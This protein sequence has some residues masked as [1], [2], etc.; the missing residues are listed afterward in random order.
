M[1]HAAI[2]AGAVAAL[3]L[4]GTRTCRGRALVA[5]MRGAAPVDCGCGCTDHTVPA[6]VAVGELHPEP[7]ELGKVYRAF[8]DVSAL[9]P[10]LSRID[11]TGLDLTP[12]GCGS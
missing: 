10:T 9:Q 3:Y 6:S 8:P 1:K 11:V 2:I 12:K 4:L 5:R 7:P